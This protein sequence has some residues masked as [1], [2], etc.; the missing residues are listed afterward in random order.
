M[1][2]RVVLSTINA[3]SCAHCGRLIEG[4]GVVGPWQIRPCSRRECRDEAGG[5][6]NLIVSVGALAFSIGLSRRLARAMEMQLMA[7][8]G[9][10]TVAQ[11]AAAAGALWRG[12]RL[13]SDGTVAA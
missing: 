1:D 10:K 2:T 8:A 7:E 6:W 4:S 9:E 13:D 5:A 12:P 11:L 3:P